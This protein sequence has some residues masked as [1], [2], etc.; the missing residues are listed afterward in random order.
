MRVP[1]VYRA[2]AVI[3]RHRKI[4]EADRILTIFSA[5]H[6][7]FD[8]VAKGVRRPASRKSGHLEELS[9]SSLLL[10]QGRTLDVV[11][12]CEM[13]ESLAP[14]RTDLERLSAAVY[15]AELVDRFSAER[16]EN[17][18]VYYL[19]LACLRGLAEGSGVA[20]TL[21]FFEV[22]M[23]GHSGF[24]PQL[25]ACASCRGPIDAVINAFSPSAGGVVCGNC[26]V[27]DAGLRPLTVNALKV[28]RLLQT[29]S[30]ADAA[31]LWLEPA[32]A[33]ELEEH[34]GRYV[35]HMLDHEVRSGE[36]LRSLRSGGRV[37]S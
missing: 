22:R 8:V 12:Q 13:L 20:A 35:R 21:R 3:L 30:Y 33:S 24:E 15:L 19:L 11:T 34:L 31:R 23:L 7:K 28:L 1:R 5:E 27:A 32:L 18:A 37:V 4:G 26:H 9:H 29:G 16:Q 2:E 6:G 17:Q 10:A 36:F 14:L 25:R